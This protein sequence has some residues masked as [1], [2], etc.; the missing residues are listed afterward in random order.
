MN[1]LRALP[2]ITVVDDPYEVTPTHIVSWN[3]TA[4]V[5]TDQNTQATKTLGRTPDL[6]AVAKG[7]RAARRRSS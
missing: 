3:G 2:G 6:V 7:F 1:A 5:L 4:W